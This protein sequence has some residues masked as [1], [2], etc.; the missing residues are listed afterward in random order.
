MICL[1][2]NNSR[3]DLCFL[4]ITEFIRILLFLP[5]FRDLL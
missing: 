3:I 5:V 4:I 2:I 1:L